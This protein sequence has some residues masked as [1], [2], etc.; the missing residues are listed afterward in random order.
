M[1][2]VKWTPTNRP[3]R[4]NSWLSPLSTSRWT[5]DVDQL[6]NSLFREPLGVLPATSKDV[7]WLPAFD[8]VEKDKEYQLRVEAAG[9]KKSDFSVSVKDGVLTI[10][11]E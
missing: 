11:G 6:F 3:L 4:R 10:T 8:V 7:D 1:T 9:M 5:S 2:L